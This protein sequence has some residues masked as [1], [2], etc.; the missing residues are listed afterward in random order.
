[1]SRLASSVPATPPSASIGTA[2]ESVSC[3]GDG[4]SDRPSPGGSRSFSDGAVVS[5]TSLVK[6][7]SA[8]LSWIMSVSACNF[9]LLTLRVVG[10]QSKM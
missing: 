3:S 5:T 9:V 7:C 2:K 10:N 6:R 1:M 8:L 4:G